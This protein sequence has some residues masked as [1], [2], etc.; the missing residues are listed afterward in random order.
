MIKPEY[1]EELGFSQSYNPIEGSWIMY[2]IIEKYGEDVVDDITDQLIKE[3]GFNTEPDYKEAEVQ[4]YTG[5]LREKFPRFRPAKNVRLVRVLMAMVDLQIGQEALLQDHEVLRN[6]EIIDNHDLE[7]YVFD[8]GT[9]AIDCI[10]R[11]LNRMSF[12][13]KD[14]DNQKDILPF[15]D[16]CT[17]VIR[18]LERMLGSFSGDPKH[19]DMTRKLR[20]SCRDNMVRL[21]RAKT[22]LMNLYYRI[23]EELKE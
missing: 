13:V 22:Y 4:A 11:A 3:M 9:V 10:L 8:G 5:F 20:M 7:S 17:L 18:Y 2:H 1:E 19:P 15:E 14:V 16:T 21:G 23:E 12:E 6:K